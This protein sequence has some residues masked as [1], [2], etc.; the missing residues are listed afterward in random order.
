MRRG[1][2]IVHP[3]AAAGVAEALV[4]GRVRGQRSGHHGAAAA[5]GA[6]RAVEAGEGVSHG[7]KLGG[8]KPEEQRGGAEGAEE[9]SVAVV[10]ELG[11][12]L[13]PKKFC[14]IFQIPRHIKSLDACIEY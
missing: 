1:E 6:A 9:Q 4:G 3:D 10:E 14:K 7:R 11:P 2:H 8:R 12:C 13:L 5:G